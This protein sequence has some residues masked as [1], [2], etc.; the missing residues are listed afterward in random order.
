MGPAN[1]I[2]GNSAAPAAAGRRLFASMGP[3][4]SI[5]GNRADVGA[6]VGGA[7]PLQWGRQIVLP[8]IAALAQVPRCETV[9]LQWGR[10]IVLPEIIQAACDGGVAYNGLQW[11]RQ[12]VLPEICS[13]S[14]QGSPGPTS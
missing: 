6:T 2:A 12:I 13:G 11:G 7:A 14:Y 4:N 10:Q 5:E 9:L 8:E 1:S 3:A